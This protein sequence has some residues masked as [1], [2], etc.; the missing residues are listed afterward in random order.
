MKKV[1]IILAAALTLGL[2]SCEKFSLTLYY[3]AKVL[4]GKHKE[5]EPDPGPP[6]PDTMVYVAAVAFPDDYDWRRDPEQG[7]VS[8]N[9]ILYENGSPLLKLPTGS[10]GEIDPDPDTHHFLNGHLY[11]E[12]CG[13]GGTVIK[14]DGEELVRWAEQEVL[15]GMVVRDGVIYTLGRDLEG[16]G[17]SFRKNGEML[18]RQNEGTVFGDFRDPS[19]GPTG[20]LVED[21]E[22][23]ISFGFKTSSG[24]SRVVDAQIYQ[25]KTSIAMY[26]IKDMKIHNYGGYYVADFESI[27]M[28]HCP[29]GNRGVPAVRQWNDI[30]IFFDGD[31]IWYL[32]ESTVGT[33]V[34]GLV[35]KGESTPVEFAGLGNYIYRG[36]EATFA[37]GGNSGVL[38]VQ[39]S[40][41]GPVM[42]RDSTY[43]FGKGGAALAGE[44]ALFVLV[45]PKERE[46][47]PFVWHNGNEDKYNINGYL[48]AIDVRLIPPNE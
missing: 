16:N 4:D 6:A 20:A 34:C 3:R 33:T 48:S 7:S 22:E 37:V 14:C 42:V 32:G 38:M 29:V 39:D 47:V 26:R 10:K 13:S 30:S 19:C 43:C 1:S 35:D 31:D 12:Y 21:L 44:K 41:E 45:N 27:M 5:E 36:A 9:L 11:T 25:V 23:S 28:V 17:F 8:G 18:L 24:L 40:R 15:K 2:L 46:A